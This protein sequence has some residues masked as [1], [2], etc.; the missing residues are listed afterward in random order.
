MSSQIAAKLPNSCGSRAGRA[1]N[2]QCR[3][4]APSSQRHTCARDALDGAHRALDSTLKQAELAGEL[5]R[6]VTWLRVVP[7]GLE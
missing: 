3:C 5:E 2:H 7:A 6:K 4:S 1:M